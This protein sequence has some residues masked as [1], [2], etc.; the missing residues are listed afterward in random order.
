MLGFLIEILTK[1]QAYQQGARNFVFLPV[2]PIDA[3]PKG[4]S[5]FGPVSSTPGS[6]WQ[7]MLNWM[8]SYNA[9][10]QGV[11]NTINTYGGTTSLWYP[12][13]RDIFDKVI[14]SPAAYGFLDV[15]TACTGN[16]IGYG[17]TKRYVFCSGNDDVAQE[18]NANDVQQIGPGS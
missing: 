10:L 4:V 16:Y 8:K 18:I 1:V 15:T 9:G 11:A 17:W 6:T 13:F 5:K 2:P 14:A 12:Q 3:T 7:G